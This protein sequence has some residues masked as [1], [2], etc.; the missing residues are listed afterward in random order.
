[1][2]AFYFFLFAL[3]AIDGVGQTLAPKLAQSGHTATLLH[4]GRVLLAGGVCDQGIRNCQNAAQIYDPATKEFTLTS[5]MLGSRWQHTATLMAD[6]RVLFTGGVGLRPGQPMAEIFDPE[7]GVFLPTGELS[8]V[9]RGYS[10]V[11]LRSGKVLVSVSPP[12]IYDP[13]TGAFTAL[14]EPAISIRD[15]IAVMMPAGWIHLSGPPPTTSWSTTLAPVNPV[16]V[17]AYREEDGQIVFEAQGY[18]RAG[19]YLQ[20]TAL[21]FDGRV[22]GIGGCNDPYGFDATSD[23]DIYDPS[24]KSARRLPN[25]ARARHGH[26]ATMLPDGRVLVTGGYLEGSPDLDEVLLFDPRTESFQTLAPLRAGRQGHTATL[27]P[28]GT[29]LVAGG[30]FSKPDAE[31]VSFERAVPAPRIAVAAAGDYAE[32]YAV[33]LNTQDRL[34][35]TVTIGKL[36]A[37]VVYFG[38]AP[39]LAGVQQIN[40]RI[41]NNVSSARPVE[42]QVHYRDRSSNRA[43]L[44][45]P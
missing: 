24:T 6:G 22:L 31:I 7:S 14:P 25:L 29:V 11:L 18:R 32:I 33:G 39:G 13:L 9:T 15:A 38:E 27:L 19:P 42:V 16:F 34:P 1:M 17:A 35:P 40:A 8:G 28:D 45:H 30:I 26:R 10:A 36:P 44:K 21:L 37:E 12:R 23:V 41:P 5:P 20:A 43:E 3:G 2:R 4:D